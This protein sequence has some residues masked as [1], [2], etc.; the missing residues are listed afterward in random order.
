MTVSSLKNLMVHHIAKAPRKINWIA[1]KSLTFRT[2]NYGRVCLMTIGF[3]LRA[4]DV[5]ADDCFPTPTFWDNLPCDRMM[6]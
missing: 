5:V 3:I 2:F 1:A 4:N 6:C